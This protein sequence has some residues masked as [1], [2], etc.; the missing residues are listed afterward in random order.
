MWKT[1][2]FLAFRYLREQKSRPLTRLTAWTA[3]FGIAVGS[4]A[5]VFAQSLAGGFQE[6]T[7]RVIL[8]NTAHITVSDK[9]AEI[10]EPS[11]AAEK[12]RLYLPPNADFASVSFD[13]AL[14]SGTKATDYALLRGLETRR[15]QKFLP[16]NLPRDERRLQI[17]LGK[18]L[19][20]KLALQKGDIA[21][22]V[23]AAN[24]GRKKNVFIGGVFETGFY[25]Y[26]AAWAILTNEDLARLRDD[27]QVSV[28]AFEIELEDAEN[29]EETARNLREK[30]GA[31][32]RVIS[33]QE[34][35]KPLFAGLQL[36]KRLAL[37]II[38]LISLLA[39]LN[40][41]AM[42]ALAVNERR[43][44]IAVLQTCGAKRRA[45]ASA[46]V[47]EGVILT[48]A[49]ALCGV[50]F[51]AVS[52]FL[53]NR[54]GFLQLPADIYSLEKIALQITPEDVLKTVLTALLL[55]TFSTL[56]PALS[57]A[58]IKPWDNLRE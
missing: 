15:L 20:E 6:K 56:L 16:P 27:A 45:I 3:F 42:L 23:T 36:E 19:A 51:G 57:A 30:L 25:E 49:G 13:G 14:I 48:L 12:L 28:N 21:E 37:L 50:L 1:A 38:S 17:Y 47:L 4:A 52:C 43:R 29:A 5:F 11:T 58:R 44:D 8:Q 55:G 39:C 24:G 22:I 31:E 9:T 46:F 35:N 26:D 34:A 10:A 40:L 2:I 33:W 41:T 53:I 32:F 7:R 18:I 54:F